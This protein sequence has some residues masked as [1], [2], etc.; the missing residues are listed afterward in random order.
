MS[1]RRVKLVHK[2]M[3]KPLRSNYKWFGNTNEGNHAGE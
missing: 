1:K 2:T 3:G